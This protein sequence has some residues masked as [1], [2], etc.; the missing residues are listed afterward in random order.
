MFFGFDLVSILCSLLSC[1][2]MRFV[3]HSTWFMHAHAL[4]IWKVEREERVELVDAWE[5]FPK[6]IVE[7]PWETTFKTKQ[8]TITACST[9]PYSHSD[10][11]KTEMEN[12][13]T[14]VSV[15]LISVSYAGLFVGL[16]LALT[17]SPPAK[18]VHYAK[19]CPAAGPNRGIFLNP[20]F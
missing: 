11:R 8:Q 18:L 13:G 6:C 16:V 15:P 3:C 4:E 1:Y 14:S 12:A 7:L 2:M 5:Q 9:V 10:N 19:K 17:T 20:L